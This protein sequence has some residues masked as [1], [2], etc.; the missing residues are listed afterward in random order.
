MILIRPKAIT[1]ASLIS[2]SAP[3]TP[4]AL[5]APG[6]TYGVG[7]QVAVPVVVPMANRANATIAPQGSG[8]YRVTKGGAVSAWD[9]WGVSATPFSGDFIVACQPRIVGDYFFSVDPN[10]AIVTSGLSTARGIVF[11]PTQIN[12]VENGAV[13]TVASYTTSDYWFLRRVGTSISVWKGQTNDI[14]TASLVYTFTGLAGDLYLSCGFYTP[15]AS[16]D[17]LASEMVAGD[18]SV[19]VFTSLQATNVGHDP[20]SAPAWW[21]AGGTTYPAF[22]A[23]SIYSMGNRV[24][25]PATHRVYESMTGTPHVVTITVASPAVV[26]WTAHGLAANTPIVLTTTGALPTGLVAGTIYYVLAPTT[27]S[28]NLS[29]T[30]GGSAIN[31]TGS[32][33]GIHTATA[34]PNKGLDP[35]ADDGSHWLDIGPSNKW[36]M[37][38][39]Y[40]GTATTDPTTIDVT[41]QPSGRIDSLAL[42]SLDGAASARI[43]VA[44]AAD[45]TIYDQTFNLLDN[46]DVSDWY[47]YF[48]EEIAKK[49]KLLVTGLP[50]YSN[51]QV[52][53]I[54]SGINVSCGTLVIGMSK[55]LGETQHDGAQVGMTDYSRKEVDDFGNYTI[56][57]RPFSDTGSFKMRIAK[58]QVDGIKKVLSD[59]R[60]TPAVYSAS[61]DYNSTL[62]FGF[63]REFNIEIDYPLESLCSI[64]IEGLT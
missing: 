26:T 9:T 57:P 3:E 4:P 33:S 46:Q 11:A 14:R 15:S 34:N 24:V 43:I 19:Q 21:Q 42:L 1:D 25:N 36:A 32:Q 7:S 29:A 63:F 44:T 40:N 41:V 38:D 37:L 12:F 16:M 20:L 13:A 18:T 61:P 5:W 59:F 47:G 48:Y 50:A 54:I 8:V 2:S 27:N 22:S 53:V 31:T 51:P 35:S 39:T 64:E 45:G 17:L 56:V 49:S 55:D 28:F 30:P 60:A 10:P 62:I 23:S 58:S 52:R 6:T